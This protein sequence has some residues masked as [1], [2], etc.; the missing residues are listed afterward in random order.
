MLILS[1]M[2]INLYFKDITWRNFTSHSKQL[3]S[4]DEPGSF[5]Q[6]KDPAE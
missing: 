6:E 3:S 5:G 4:A 1:V 2:E